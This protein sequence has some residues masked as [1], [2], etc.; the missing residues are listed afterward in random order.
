MNKYLLTAALLL[1]A[2]LLHAQPVPQDTAIHTGHLANGLTYYIRYNAEPKKKVVMYLVN[3][4]G[5]ILEDDDQQGLAH[6]MEHMNFN[7]TRHYPKNKLEDF[8]QRAG[9][10]FGADLNAYTSYDETVYQ[11]PL[12]LDNPSMLYKGLDILHDWTQFARLTTADIEQ[13]RGVVLEEERLG[14]GAAERMRR[15]YM[16]LLLN[17]SRYAQRTPMGLHSILTTFKPEQLRRFHADWYRPDLQ[18]VIVVG[19][20][21]A[22]KTAAY[23]RSH[24]SDLKNPAREKPR[25]YYHIPLTGESRFALI[26]DPEQPQTVLDIFIKHNARAL[27]TEADY[28]YAI[29]LALFQQLLATRYREQSLLPGNAYLSASAG[30]SGL[31]GGLDAFSFE[32]VPKQ[33]H[34]EQ[35]VRQAWTLVAQ[36]RKEGF[37]DEE[38]QQARENYLSN[39]EASLKEANKTPSTAYVQALQSLFLQGA[40]QPSALWQR[41]F[42][43]AHLNAITTRDIDSIAREYIRDTDRGILL[44]APDSARAGLPGSAGIARW[45]HEV[46]NSPLPSYRYSGGDQKAL[47]VAP[48]AG[49]KVMK[50]DSIP[51]L[52][53]T[54]LTLGNGVKVILK[55]THYKNDEILFT[56]FAPGGLSLSRPG[57]YASAASA[58]SVIGSMGLAG[59]DPVQLS[60][61][62]TG[63][64]VNAGA[65]ISENMQG[66]QGA[67]NRANLLTALQLIYL[68]FTQPRKD[69][70]I[71]R[72][73]VTS[74]RESLVNKYASPAN[75][76]R[77]TLG[78]FLNGY[79]PRFRPFTADRVGELNLDSAYAFYRERFADAAAFTFVFTGNFDADSIRPLLETYLGGLPATH[80]HEAA[81]DHHIRMP[82]GRIT[83]TV[84]AGTENQANVEIVLSGPFEYTPVNNLLLYAAGEVLQLK[85]LRDIR[86][87]EAEVYAPAVKTVASK[88]PGQRFTFSV[89]FG[90]APE[91]VNHLVGIVEQEL[92]SLRRS[93]P[94]ATDIGK[95]K[96]AYRQ[97]M[98]EA[99]P[100]NAFWLSYISTKEQHHEA[101]TGISNREKY[102]A[103]V[104]PATVKEWIK[105]HLTGKNFITLELLPREK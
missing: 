21:D 6:F 40:A 20:I 7:G 66:V 97:Q 18:A 95:V 41:D 28:R 103:A 43:R 94:S 10:R 62:L 70:A 84:T 8:L 92:E 86:E 67:C 102:L 59:Y 82:E 37:T 24:F 104:T 64:I 57:N 27:H 3:K 79:Q 78:Y 13:E 69:T 25:V 29:K 58:A 49:T 51:D 23:I 91:N 52:G 36:V 74:T 17:N 81:A 39:M 16:P 34:M 89:S 47:L 53:I 38:L 4:A 93:G 61:K 73:I 35:A 68:Q 100:T 60:R 33:G 22:E 11:L 45:L 32:V 65:F 75:I 96:Q 19:D 90:C 5:S 54:T 31:L 30:V 56:G 77:D 42:V 85:L 63:R 44:L 80:R 83:K 99:L 55:P 50:A 26:T 98:E 101:L 76:Y 48:P 1:A 15:Q 9:V 88:Y 105:V 72:H 46:D 87:K 71:F 12:P 14:L 2:R